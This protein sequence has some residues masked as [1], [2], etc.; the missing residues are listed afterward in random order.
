MTKALRSL[1]PAR[2]R[3]PWHVLCDNESFLKSKGTLRAY[4]ATG[5]VPWHVPARSPDLNP[6]EKFW[7]WLRRRL[8]YLDLQDLQAKRKPLTKAAYRARVLR[9][10]RT[11]KA[12]SVAR[13][14]T[15]GLLKV[16]RE[17]VAGRGKASRGQG[18]PCTFRVPAQG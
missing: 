8:R 5:V 11:T 14:C 4:K 1:W 17:V 2:K 3:G 13:K 15:R 12:R 18:G 6:V 7:S 9:V 10:C 16:C